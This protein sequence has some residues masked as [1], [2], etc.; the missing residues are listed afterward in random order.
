M[1]L[2]WEKQAERGRV[3]CLGE[4]GECRGRSTLDVI[5][6]YIV[7]HVTSVITLRDFVTVNK[8]KM[9]TN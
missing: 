5:I 3:P 7:P 4:P 9:D 2:L 6:L 1:I 8:I